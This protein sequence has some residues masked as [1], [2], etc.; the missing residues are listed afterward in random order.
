MTTTTTTDTKKN[1]FVVG[2]YYVFSKDVGFAGP[3]ATF[4]AAADECF[5]DDDIVLTALS[6]SLFK[7]KQEKKTPVDVVIDFNKK[8]LTVQGKDVTINKV[9]YAQGDNELEV[10]DLAEWEDIIDSAYTVC[11]TVTVIGTPPI[12]GKEVTNEMSDM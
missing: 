8:L 3:Y 11:R 12:D 7:E 1:P 5:Y 10:E 6:P 4:A 9:A 2:K